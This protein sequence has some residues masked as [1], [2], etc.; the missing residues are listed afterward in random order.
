MLI[1]QIFY[2]SRRVLRKIVKKCLFV[3]FGIINSVKISRGLF[4]W[5]TIVI[6]ML[7]TFIFPFIVGYWYRNSRFCNLIIFLLMFGLLTMN[8][9]FGE[10]ILKNICNRLYG[11]EE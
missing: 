6:S 2:R 8:L 9:L 3:L 7:I 4:Y 1:E 11:K 10:D 5:G